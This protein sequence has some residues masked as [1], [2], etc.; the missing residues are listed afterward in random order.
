[1]LVARTVRGVK[2]PVPLLVKRRSNKEETWV[3]LASPIAPD[4]PVD[5]DLR[6]IAQVESDRIVCIDDLLVRRNFPQL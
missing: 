4:V 1:M 2:S 5:A 6:A 3:T